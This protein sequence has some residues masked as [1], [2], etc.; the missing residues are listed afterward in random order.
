METKYKNLPN[1]L[2]VFRICVIPVIVIT[3][4]FDD[5]IFAHRLGAFLF[6][7]AAVTDFLDGY[8]A[9]SYGLETKFG[10]MLDPIADK[11]LVGAV[12]LMLVAFRKVAELPCLLILMR[13][14]FI[15]GLREFL[16]EIHVSVPVSKLAQVKTFIQM[17]S[18]FLLLLGSKGSGIGVMD[19]IGQV[20][21]W[22][23]S[24]VT[25]FTGYVY[26]KASLK[27]F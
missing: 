10:K 14:F 22:I 7:L 18:L 26:F 24:I 6:A 5:K 15:A 8:L 16:A 19:S 25:I 13:E 11:L 9:R 27:Y 17:F 4:Y 20:F 3:F 1:I 23:A 2:T 21:L 12:L